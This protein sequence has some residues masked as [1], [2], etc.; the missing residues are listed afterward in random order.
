MMDASVPMKSHMTG[1]A[2]GHSEA[3]G[4][5]VLSDIHWARRS[6]G[7]HG[8]QVAVRSRHPRCRWTSRIRASPGNHAGGTGANQEGRHHIPGRNAEAM[9]AVKTELAGLRTA[10]LITIRINPEKST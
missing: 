4:F 2:M 9:P 3:A 1:I 6:P 5:A 7:R 10:S 8:L